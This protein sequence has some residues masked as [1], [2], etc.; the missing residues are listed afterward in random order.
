MLESQL[1]STLCIRL[2]VIVSQ[3]GHQP[4]IFA[5][6]TPGV[7]VPDIPDVETGLKLALTGAIKDSIVGEDRLAQYL[8]ALLNTHAAPLQWKNINIEGFEDLGEPCLEDPSDGALDESIEEVKKR[9][10]E[11]RRFSDH[12]QDH[13]VLDV[14][15]ALFRTFS[16]FQGNLKNED[17]LESLIETQFTALQKA[18]RIPLSS[19]DIGRNKVAKKVL[20]LYRTGRLG[21][22]TLDTPSESAPSTEGN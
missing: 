6:D 16:A 22:Y 18:F 10:K 19:G 17:D 9:R 4:S 14:R 15:R 20:N 21:H 13:V 12:T 1:S 8:L 2:L 5:L 11:K 7:L 3:I